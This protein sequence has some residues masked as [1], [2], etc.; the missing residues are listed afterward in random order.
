M[1]AELFQNLRKINKRLKLDYNNV[2]GYWSIINKVDKK[3]QKSLFY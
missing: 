3:F 1:S 2:D